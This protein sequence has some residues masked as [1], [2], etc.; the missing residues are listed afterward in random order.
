MRTRHKRWA[1]LWVLIGSLL[2]A[3]LLISKPAA[4]TNAIA[5][6]FVGYTNLPAN[7][8]RFA[9]FS[10]SNQAP[11]AVRWR[12]QWVEVE[13][14]QNRKAPVINPTLPGLPRQPTLKAGGSIRMAIGEPFYGSETGRW[15]FAMW[16]SRHTWQSRWLD[17]SFKHRLPLRLG[18]ILLV[19]GQRILDPTNHVTV[20]SKWLERE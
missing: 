16:F 10:A 3:I 12:G 17:F 15:R 11:Y 1:L 7:P 4:T 6:T 5:I 13:G 8:T 18:P 20:T 14:E 2:L 19:D 9:V